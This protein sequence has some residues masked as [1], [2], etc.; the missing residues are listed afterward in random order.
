M[1]FAV[2]VDHKEKKLNDREKKNKY[3]NLA[4]ELEITVEH[5]SDDNTNCNWC[6]WYSHQRTKKGTG[7]LENKRTIGDHP[8]NCIIEIG[9]NTVKSP[10]DL[11]GLA[12]KGTCEKLSRGNNNNNNNNDNMEMRLGNWIFVKESKPPRSQ[13][14]FY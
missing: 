13:N 12:V 3:F 5:E 7:G 8:N 11:R 6:S 10:G 1:D 4:R 9:Q 14:C 2:A